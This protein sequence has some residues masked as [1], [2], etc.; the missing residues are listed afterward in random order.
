MKNHYCITVNYVKSKA[1]LSSLLI[2]IKFLKVNANLSLIFKTKKNG[3]NLFF[4]F[5]FI[6]ISNSNIPRP[7]PAGSPYFAY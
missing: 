3:Y 2:T 4:I 7:T 6:F 5:S 1:V